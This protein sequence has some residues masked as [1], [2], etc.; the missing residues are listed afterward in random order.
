MIADAGPPDM[1]K[2]QVFAGIVEAAFR[3]ERARAVGR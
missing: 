1:K 3:S 2:A